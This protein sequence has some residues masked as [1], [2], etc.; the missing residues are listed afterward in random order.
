MKI[1]IDLTAIYD[2][3]SGIER[4][5]ASLASEMVGHR[6]HQFLLIFKNQVHPMFQEKIGQS[7]V[8]GVVIKGKNKLVFNQI[9]LPWKLYGIL[10]DW[11]LFLAFP[12]PVL[13]FKKN[14]VSAMHDISCWDCPDT[15]KWLSKW[16]FRISHRT[17]M[18]KCKA[19]VTIS[20][21][22]ENRIA[23]RLHYPK[24]KIWKI[25]C[26]VDRV[27]FERQGDRAVLERI[28]EDYHLPEHY[29]LS[30]S[31]LE[32]RKNLELLLKAYHE[33]VLAGETK[34]PLVLAGRMGWKMEHFLDSVNETVR[35]NIIITG[36]IKEEELPYLYAG[37]DVFI[38]PSRYEGFGL[39]PLEAMACGTPVLSSDAASMPEVLGEAAAYFESGNAEHLKEKIMALEDTDERDQMTARGKAQAKKYSWEKEA[40]KLILLMGKGTDSQ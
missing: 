3:F 14:I 1:V 9:L 26:G 2:R 32:P 36:F 5:A 11:Y 40:E 28:R 23:E 30:L 16:Y 37:A 31:T 29:I 33:L 19:I 27:F 21:F 25:Y 7:N 8:T 38:F 17:A 4:Y 6:E 22:S 12:V 39:P 35:K 13:F 20:D 24:E 15:M 10:A 18:L 34:L